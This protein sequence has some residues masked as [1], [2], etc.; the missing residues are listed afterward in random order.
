MWLTPK[1]HSHDQISIRMLKICSNSIC[2]PFEYIYR[3]CLETGK[4]QNE[5]KKANV[6]AVCKKGD[7]QIIKKLPSSFSTTYLW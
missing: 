2:Q 7:K 5:W 1:P 4:F 3:Q 6:V